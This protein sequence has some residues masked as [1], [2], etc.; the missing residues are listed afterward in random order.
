MNYSIEELRKRLLDYYG[1][2]IG[3]FPI[4]M[5]DVVRVECMSDR[6]VLEEAIK[7]GYISSE[8]VDL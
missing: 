3:F 6:E 4:A 1:T 7:L 5:G 8:E 2:A